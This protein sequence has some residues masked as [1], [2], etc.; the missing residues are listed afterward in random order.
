MREEKE[1][2]FWSYPLFRP[3]CLLLRACLGYTQDSQFLGGM[4]MPTIAHR[5]T[6]PSLYGPKD[7][8]ILMTPEEFDDA[9]F[10]DGW[11]YELINGVL[12][13]TPIPL[14]KERDPN[15]ELGYWLRYYRDSRPQGRMFLVTLHEHTVQ[16]GRNRR[17][18]D[19][20][21]WVNFNRVPAPD[22]AP[23]VIAEFVSRRRRDR[24]RDYEDKRDEYM[25]INVKEYWVIDRFKRTLTVFTKS[26][27]R[28]RERI[29]QENETYTTPLLPGFELSI[30][31]LFVA[32][33]FWPEREG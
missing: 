15:E 14:E 23:T 17:R 2:E 27:G 18:A 4:L 31:K 24:K 6:K 9:E 8:G 7:N 10:K 26:R 32:A 20:V 25:A 11:R 22:D 16:V 21:V 28:I 12:I 1:A 19:R 33:D 30:A 13:V 3:C 5:I 29:I